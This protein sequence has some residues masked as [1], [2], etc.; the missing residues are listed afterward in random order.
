MKPDASVAKIRWEADMG[1][2]AT[3]QRTVLRACAICGDEVALAHHVGVPVS[4][5]VDWILGDAMITT[6]EFL[7]LVDIV[8]QDNRTLILSNRDFIARVRQRSRTPS[9][10]E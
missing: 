3:R 9:G 5:V 10:S 8:L 2:W 7:L 6:D 4:R 1:I